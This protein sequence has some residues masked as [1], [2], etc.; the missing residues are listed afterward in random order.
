MRCKISPYSNMVVFYLHGPTKKSIYDQSSSHFAYPSAFEI[1]DSSREN[2]KIVL[3]YSNF[4]VHL[5]S[6]VENV[7]NNCLV[8]DLEIEVVQ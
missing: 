6:G 4:F 8:N 3:A 7:H 1:V 5:L 2:I